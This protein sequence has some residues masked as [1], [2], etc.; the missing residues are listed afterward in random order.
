MS[1]RPEWGWQWEERWL[2][3]LVSLRLV[4][5]VLRMALSLVWVGVKWP[6]GKPE[7][8]SAVLLAPLVPGGSESRPLRGQHR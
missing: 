6:K 2:A 7:P 1:V 3:S 5:G 8:G 4:G